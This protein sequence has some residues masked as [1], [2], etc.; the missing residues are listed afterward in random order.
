MVKY[1]MAL[2]LI[3]TGCSHKKSDEITQ[4]KITISD[5]LRPRYSMPELV[6]VNE[7]GRLV[8]LT[9]R[10]NTDKLKAQKHVFSELNHQQLDTIQKAIM[11][12]D[13]S[14]FTHI[15]FNETDTATYKL[16]ISFLTPTKRITKVLVGNDFSTET[17]QLINYIY[18]LPERLKR[19][20]L[21]Q[22]YH[23]STDEICY[24]LESSQP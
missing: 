22:S 7:K 6:E 19:Y 10:F 16:K 2:L 11:A 5:E 9:N 24:E 1:L 23:F 15:A 13:K 8:I 17:H 18:Q 3:F 12:M 14:D 20:D 21:N 4:F